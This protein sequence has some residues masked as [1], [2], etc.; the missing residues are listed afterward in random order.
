MDLFSENTADSHP[1]PLAERA[2]PRRL[3]EFV[4]QEHLLGEGKALR[5]L[6]ERDDVPSL[7]FW[8]PPGSGKTT[9]AR[10]LAAHSGAEFHQLSAVSSGVKE[11]RDILSTARRM[12]STG[13][14]TLL[15]I[16]EIH[17]F[18]KSQQDALLHGVEAGTVTLI[19]A[20]TENPSFEIIAP[21]LSR[22]RVYVLKPLGGG[23]LREI[24]SR[25][26]R[27]DELLCS[28]GVSVKNPEHLVQVA[29]GDARIMLNV[30]EVAVDLAAAAGTPPLVITDREINEALQHR[31]RLYDQAGEEH[32]NTVSAFIKSLRGS[33]PDAALYWMARM[34]EAGEDPLFVARRMVILASEDIGNAEPRALP[35]ATSCFLAVERVGMPEARIILAQTATFLASAPKSNASYA[36]IEAAL[37]DVRARPREDVPL[38]LRNAPTGLMAQQ[39]YGAGYVYGHA[40]PGTGSDQEYLPEALAGRVYY[41]PSDHGEERTIGERLRLWWKRRE[42]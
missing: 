11:V 13:R 1:P 37:E 35:L 7:V 42:R 39:G 2:R 6:I 16:D 15:F 24:L 8:G 20:T 38:H 32:F 27:R 12:R 28:L 25:A 26:L 40:A 29:G 31:H 41:R 36:A 10:I 19:G 17:R 30:L 18:S 14:R 34:L 9:L 23:E 5:V 3:D 33:D 4:G 22:C 21:L